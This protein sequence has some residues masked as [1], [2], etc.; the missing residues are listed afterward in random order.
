[1]TAANLVVTLPGAATCWEAR[2]VGRRLVLLD[3]MPGH[4]RENIQRELEAGG[5]DVCTPRSADLV[6][7]VLAA[8]DRDQRSPAAPSPA[9]PWH[10]AFVAALASIGVG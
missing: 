10:A 3:A 2:V 4:G 1:M 5:A 9:Q 6:A 7:G 8:L